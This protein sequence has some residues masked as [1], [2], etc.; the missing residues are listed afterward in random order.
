MARSARGILEVVTAILLGLVSVTT[1]VG[2]FQA[3]GLSS[4]AAEHNG[5]SQQLRDRNL[6]AIVSAELVLRDDSAKLF[7]A[8]ALSSEAVVFPER[9]EEIFALQE[10]IVST[11]SPAFVE[12][13]QAWADSGFGEE[14]IPIGSPAYQEALFAQAHSMQYISAVTDRIAAGYEHKAGGLTIASVLFALALFLLGVGG[15]MRSWLVA[16]VLAGTAAAI[17]LAGIGVMLFAML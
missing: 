17:Y 9:I 1:S 6:T 3:A 2:A 10:F 11:A 5:I 4:L 8:L 16:L 7:D 13:W 12:A 14:L 15:V